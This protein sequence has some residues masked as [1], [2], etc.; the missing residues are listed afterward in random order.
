MNYRYAYNK[1]SIQIKV[2][3]NNNNKL[4]ILNTFIHGLLS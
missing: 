3:Y 2:D 4:S 1:L